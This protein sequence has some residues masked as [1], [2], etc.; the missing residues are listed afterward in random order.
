MDDELQNFT[1]PPSAAEGV[2]KGLRSI[3]HKMSLIPL[4]SLPLFVFS[5]PMVAAATA[6]ETLDGWINKGSFGK[7]AKSALVGGVDTAMTAIGSSGI[8]WVINWISALATGDSLGELSRRGT[9]GI[10]DTV[11]PDK[12]PESRYTMQPPH[13]FGAAPMTVGY[14]PA[15]VGYSAAPMMQQYM[16]APQH[17]A[18]VD[19]SGQ[20]VGPNHF[21]NMIAQQRGQDPQEMRANWMRDSDNYADMIA[22]ER[23]AAE[24]VERDRQA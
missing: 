23:A 22:Y 5:V 8:G 9:Q 20:A 17:P 2:A 12:K 6:I 19:P 4:F 24:G 7:G 11:A 18:M 1:T 10:V 21:T 3:A 13:M 14:V 16:A 15:A